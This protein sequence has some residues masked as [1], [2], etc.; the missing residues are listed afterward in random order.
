MDQDIFI[1]L[2]KIKNKIGALLSHINT[3]NCSFAICVRN[4]DTKPVKR[5]K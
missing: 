5:M 2:K 4:K 3:E 1:W